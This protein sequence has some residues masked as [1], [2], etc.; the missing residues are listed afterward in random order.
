[1]RLSIHNLC[2][3]YGKKKILDQLNLELVNPGIWALIGPNGA[4]KTTLLDC[5]AN[6][7]TFDSGEISINGKKH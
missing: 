3:S 2:K 7:Q 1:M 6:L 4:G 5:I